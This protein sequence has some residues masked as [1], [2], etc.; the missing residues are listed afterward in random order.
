MANELEGRLA[1]YKTQ[2]K[3]PRVLITGDNRAHFGATVYA[4]DMIRK[5]G[6]RTDVDR[7]ARP[8]TPANEHPGILTSPMRRDLITGFI[9]T[10]TLEIV[11]GWGG[12]LTHYKAQPKTKEMEQKIRHR[13]AEDRAGRAGGRR[14]RSRSSP[15][16]S[17]PRCSR[18]SRRR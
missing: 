2:V 1:S 11:V 15:R 10:L 6:H 8:P 3:E 12:N 16:T 4:L 18:T 14:G 13:D 9:L 17:R 7:D 5:V